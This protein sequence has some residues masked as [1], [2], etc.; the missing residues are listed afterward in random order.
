MTFRNSPKHI[1]FVSTS[2]AENSSCDKG[3]KEQISVICD[4]NK[5]IAKKYSTA[6]FVL[7]NLQLRKCCYHVCMVT[8]LHGYMVTWLHGYMV[9]W[10]LGS[11]VAEQL[12]TVNVHAEVPG[13]GMTT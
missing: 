2:F 5:Q 10:L 12:S 9:A 8:W 6:R 11:P 4:G 1:S 3:G 7:T 13:P